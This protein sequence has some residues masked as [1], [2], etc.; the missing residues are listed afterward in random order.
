[1][2]APTHTCSVWDWDRLG[3][4]YYRVPGANS[5]GG[6]QALKGLGVREG[7]IRD[8]GVG[9]D[10]EDMLPLLP[11]EAVWVGRGYQA[12]GRVCVR[13]RPK[14]RPRPK[15]N[16]L[17]SRP[18]KPAIGALPATAPP[19]AGDVVL[20]ALAA[21]DWKSFGYGM[22]FVMAA[23]RW[24]WAIIGGAGYAGYKLYTAEQA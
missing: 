9:V 6:W 16:Q 12:E 21:M 1:M 22:L 5:V 24:K 19:A 10:I 7:G 11:K 14:L 4:D 8:H 20:D 18:T 3:Y 15:S 23:K 13:N 17:R 2:N